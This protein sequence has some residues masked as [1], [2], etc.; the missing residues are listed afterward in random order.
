MHEPVD[1]TYCS[2]IQLYIKSPYKCKDELLT[3]LKTTKSVPEIWLHDPA[4][5]NPLDLLCVQQRKMYFISKW[6]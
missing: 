6:N 4:N 3:N 2:N 5:L 1:L